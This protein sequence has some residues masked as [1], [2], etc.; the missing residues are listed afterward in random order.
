MSM[1]FAD[2]DEL[3]W[4]AELINLIGVSNINHYSV[5]GL[6]SN[7]PGLH[8]IGMLLPLTTS[9]TGFEYLCDFQYFM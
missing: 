8:R 7:E 5:D 3:L 1:K 4:V 2:S 9:V 6:V